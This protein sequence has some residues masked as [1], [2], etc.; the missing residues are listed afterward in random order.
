MGPI[1]KIK[2]TLGSLSSDPGLKNNTSLVL[3]VHQ[4]YSSTDVFRYICHGHKIRV[5]VK[6][7]GKSQ[8]DQD[9]TGYGVS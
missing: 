5:F 9:S 1:L 7:V 6:T 8:W 4:F 3:N 2:T